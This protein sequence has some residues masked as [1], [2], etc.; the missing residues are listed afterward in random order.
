MSTDLHWE[1]WGARDPYFGVLTDPKFRTADITA[2]AKEEFFMTGRVHVDHVLNVCRA[3]LDSTFAPQRVLD[4]GCGVGRLVIPFAATAPDVVGMDIS[5]SMLAE[6]RRNC[7]ER[8]AREARLVESDDLLSAAE[9]E[10]DLV[11]TCIVLQHIEVPRG[12]VLFQRLVDKVRPGGIGAMHVTFGWDVYAGN[13]GQPPAPVAPATPG[14]L[15]QIKAGIKG[16]VGMSDVASLAL[17]TPPSEDPEMQMNFYN[18]SELLFILQQ[19]RCGHLYTELT[20]HGGALGAFMF[21]RKAG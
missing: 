7:D 12:R 5:P 13:Y 15:A 16:L 8:G 21:F 19:A 18:L 20:D 10:F 1:R 6:A 14:P 4:F 9:G 11:H 2:E 3:H 17:L